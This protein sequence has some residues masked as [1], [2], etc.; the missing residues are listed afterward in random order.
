MKRNTRNAPQNNSAD[1][2]AS[3]RGIPRFFKKLPDEVIELLCIEFEAFPSRANERHIRSFIGSN[4]RAVRGLSIE[5]LRGDRFKLTH[6]V[7][8][9]HIC[10]GTT[11]LDALES[12]NTIR[13]TAQ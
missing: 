3:R 9:N 12:V 4:K 7:A 2:N 10:T 1:R 8:G 6:P 11:F 5:S 13:A